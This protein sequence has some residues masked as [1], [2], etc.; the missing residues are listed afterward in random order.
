LNDIALELALTKRTTI[1]PKPISL[2]RR[3]CAT[4]ARAS[5][6]NR[7]SGKLFDAVIDVSPG[8]E[9]LSSLFVLQGI[10]D[11]SRLDRCS[12]WPAPRRQRSTPNLDSTTSVTTVPYDELYTTPK[13][14]VVI[15]PWCGGRTGRLFLSRCRPLAWPDDVRLDRRMPSHSGSTPTTDHYRSSSAQPAYP[16][17]NG[18]ACRLLSKNAQLGLTRLETI[19]SRINCRGRLS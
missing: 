18:S 7:P 19:G 2:K 8:W 11:A 4:G 9:S 10:R 17:L 6:Q 12:P 3:V 14:I 16:R 15:L 13:K 1:P 5:H